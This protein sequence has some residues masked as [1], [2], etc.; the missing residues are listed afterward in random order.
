MEDLMEEFVIECGSVDTGIAMRKIL[1]DDD[2]RLI[3]TEC[4]ARSHGKY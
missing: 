4:I 1:D 3:D 2:D